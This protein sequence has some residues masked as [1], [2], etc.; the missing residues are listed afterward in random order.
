M[1]TGALMTLTARL[2]QA[3]LSGNVVV[4]EATVDPWRDTP[5][6]LR[7]YRRLTGADFVLLTGTPSEIGRLWQFF[8]VYYKRVAQGNPP[9]VDWLTQKPETFDVQHSDGVFIVDPAGQERVAD[10]GM[11]DVGGHLRAGLRALLNEHGLQNL[12]RPQLPWTAAGVL[13]DLYSLMDKEIPAVAVPKVNP[14]TAAAARRAL[15]GSPGALAALHQQGGQLLGAENE[16]IARLRALRG[17]PVVVNAWASWCTPCRSEFSLFATDAARYGRRVAFLGVDTND[18]ASDAGSFLAKH[19]VSYPSYQSS[20]SALGSLAVLEGLPTTIF[21]DRT[22]KVIGVHPGQYQSQT[23][24][25][26]DI[27]RFALG[28]RG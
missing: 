25:D 6:R 27:D 11:P 15:T 20:S 22:G 1:T 26:N 8:G 3:G 10:A 23:A 19:P 17:Y 18:S 4:A 14:P 28:A 21:I 24:L 12:E 9:D 16:L 5:A 2:A 13:D 7:A